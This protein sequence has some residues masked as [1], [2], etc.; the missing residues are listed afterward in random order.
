MLLVRYMNAASC[1]SASQGLEWQGSSTFT[2]FKAMS[3]RN[4][5]GLTDDLRIRL[6]RHNSGHVLDTAKWKPWRLKTY[7]GFSDRS[8]A[9]QFERY[10]KSSSGRAFLKKR[11]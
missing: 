1:D 2:F 4:G 8:Q 10:L 5:T 9:V 7:V 3:I 11:L 6:K